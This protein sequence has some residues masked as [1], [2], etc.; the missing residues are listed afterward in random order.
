MVGESN[1][2]RLAAASEGR[3]GQVNSLRRHLK[4]EAQVLHLAKRHEHGH[5]SLVH[6]IEVRPGWWLSRELYT[7]CLMDIGLFTIGEGELS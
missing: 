7:T 5:V 4:R 1:L 6:N 3:A 2:K